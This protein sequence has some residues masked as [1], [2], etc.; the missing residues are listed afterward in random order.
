MTSFL[1]AQRPFGQNKNK[2]SR[3]S[4]ASSRNFDLTNFFKVPRSELS[5]LLI[6]KKEASFGRPR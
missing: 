5:M 6:L 3:W 1:P 4:F 2:N